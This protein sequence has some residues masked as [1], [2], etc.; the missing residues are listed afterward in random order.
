MEIELDLRE[1]GRLCLHDNRSKLL[2]LPVTAGATLW[3]FIPGEREEDCR[4][5]RCLYRTAFELPA[6]NGYLGLAIDELLVQD[7]EEW[8]RYHEY[9]YGDFYGNY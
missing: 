7:P 6:G 8:G 9:I 5:E 2:A 1:D 4:W 3:R